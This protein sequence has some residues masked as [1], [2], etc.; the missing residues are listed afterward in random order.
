MEN[1][2]TGEVKPV[3]EQELED[4]INK[5][6]NIMVDG[7]L[8]DFLSKNISINGKSKLLESLT[9]FI[10][11]KINQNSKEILERVRYQGLEM[12]QESLVVEKQ[13]PSDMKKHEDRIKS[14]LNKEDIKKETEKQ[15]KSIRSG[16]KAFY[17]AIVAEQ[18]VSKMKDRKKD[19]MNIHDIFLFRSKQLGYKK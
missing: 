2:N 19:L 5:S 7:D 3:M 10:D 8:D 13:T 16:E 4:M 18:M 14:L 17:R 11:Y 12:V 15:S 1:I 9:E 6:L